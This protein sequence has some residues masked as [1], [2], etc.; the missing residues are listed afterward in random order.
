[1]GAAANAS[2]FAT[3]IREQLVE[4]I[5]FAVGKLQLE[6]APGPLVRIEFGRV[7][8]ESLHVEP[9][10]ASQQPAHL[11]SVMDRAPIPEQHDVP[12]PMPQEQAQEDGDL[13]MGDVVEVEMRV[14]PTP[15]TRRADR[16]GGN[17][18]DA[19]VAVAMVHHRR[20]PA[21]RPCTAHVRD[22]QKAALIK[23]DQMGLQVAGFFLMARHL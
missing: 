18:R 2:D 5:G 20:R 16:D 12:A 9:R 22:E 10:S 6:V 21:G 3:Q 15:V 17:G 13:D 1:M 4:P 23:E 19:V 11:G 7:R 8:R 14:E